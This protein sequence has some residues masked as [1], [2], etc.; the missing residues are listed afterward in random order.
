MANCVNKFICLPDNVCKSTDRMADIVN[1]LIVCLILCLKS[2]DRMVNRVDPDQTV[3]E[4]QFDQG[5][6]CLLRPS[7]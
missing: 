5:L 1:K 2:S 4:E 6:Q 3:P 7:V